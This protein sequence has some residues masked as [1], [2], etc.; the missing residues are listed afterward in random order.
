VK[1]V[2]RGGIYTSH[3][4]DSGKYVKTSAEGSNGR[5]EGRTTGNS[6]SKCHR[7]PRKYDEQETIVCLFPSNK[8]KTLSKGFRRQALYIC[9]W[10]VRTGVDDLKG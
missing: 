3:L 10:C 4:H 9:V 1:T 7:N 6:V 5:R 8:C 2:E